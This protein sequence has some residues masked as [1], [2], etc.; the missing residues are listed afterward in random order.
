MLSGTDTYSGDYFWKDIVVVEV[1]DVVEESDKID[2]TFTE[3]VIFRVASKL[4]LRLVTQWQLLLMWTVLVT[5][6]GV[7]TLK[8]KL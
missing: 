8:I 1:G 2:A 5:L 7:S 3:E 4:D 6:N